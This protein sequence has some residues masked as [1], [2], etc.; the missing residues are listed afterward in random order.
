MIMPE[1]GV[2]ARD[3]DILV[4]TTVQVDLVCKY[5]GPLLSQYCTSNTLTVCKLRESS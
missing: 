2:T 5:A 4:E 1:M 3:R